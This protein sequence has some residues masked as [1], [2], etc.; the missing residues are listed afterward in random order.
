MNIAK[1][2]LS[3]IEIEDYMLNTYQR[4]AHIFIFLNK[5]N[6]QWQPCFTLIWQPCLD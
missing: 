1:T 4:Y 5:M 6:V 2:G 3:D